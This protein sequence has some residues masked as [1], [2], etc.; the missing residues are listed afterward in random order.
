[1]TATDKGL[2]S[3]N[4]ITRRMM[5]QTVGLAAACAGRAASDAGPCNRS[6]TS[7]SDRVADSNTRP[8]FDYRLL[9]GWIN[10]N[11]NRP[12]VGKRWPIT[13]I[14]DQTVKEYRAFLRTAR[15][16]CFNVCV[17]ATTRLTDAWGE[18]IGFL[19]RLQVSVRGCCG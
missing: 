3:S 19:P 10:D 5:L 18:A 16:Y 8:A 6:R 17:R 14:D 1:M 4:A 2:E 13:D 12:L 11:S 9:L 15:E 7:A